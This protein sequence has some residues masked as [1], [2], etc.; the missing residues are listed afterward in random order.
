MVKDKK[1]VINGLIWVG[2]AIALGALGAHA[3]KKILTV[4]QLE[5]FKTG[6]TYQQLGG[7]LVI[8]YGLLFSREIKMPRRLLQWG[9]GCF[10]LSIYIL[11]FK[12]KLSFSVKFLGP[13]TPVGGVLMMASIVS[14]IWMLRKSQSEG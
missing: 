13:I 7:I 2:T 9:I 10:S 12:D 1:T 8:V 3:L 6:V 11:S 14:A 5:S 4:E